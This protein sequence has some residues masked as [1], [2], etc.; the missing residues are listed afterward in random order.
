M[1]RPTIGLDARLAC[2]CPDHITD[3]IKAINTLHEVLDV[4]LKVEVSTHAAR[5]KERPHAGVYLYA[6]A[7]AT[8]KDIIAAVEEVV[9]FSEGVAFGFELGEYVATVG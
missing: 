3:H 5:V 6:W 4:A 1:R 9:D 7:Y 2:Y 8:A